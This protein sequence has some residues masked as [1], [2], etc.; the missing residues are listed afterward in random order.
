M[1]RQQCWACHLD[2]CMTQVLHQAKIHWKTNFLDFVNADVHSI[3][4]LISHVSN[5]NIVTGDD[6][7]GRVT[8]RLQ[9]VP[10]IKR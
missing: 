1:T 2:L 3:F 9:N 6:V 4:R 8:V 5:L 10:G 7:S